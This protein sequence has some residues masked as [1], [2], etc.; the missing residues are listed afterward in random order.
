[1]TYQRVFIYTNCEHLWNIIVLNNPMVGWNI[2][3]PLTIQLYREQSWHMNLSLI[4]NITIH[5]HESLYTYLSINYIVSIS[6]EVS[7]PRHTWPYLAIVVGPQWHPPRAPR[8][9]CATGSSEPWPGAACWCPG[10][11]GPHWAT[12]GRKRTLRICGNIVI[13]NTGNT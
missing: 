10:W 5:N 7:I 8:V 4:I 1:M 13:G 9:F 3:Y 12:P 6:H 2:N 11:H